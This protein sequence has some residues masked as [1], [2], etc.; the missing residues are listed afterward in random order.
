MIE[1]PNEPHCIECRLI[2]I[3]AYSMRTLTIPGAVGPSLPRVSIPINTRI[4][5]A[6][7]AAIKH[8]YGICTIQLAFLAGAQEASYYAVHEI[9]GPP[10][11]ALGVLSLT[12][13]N[14][15]AASELAGEQREIVL[16]IISGEANE[17]GRFA[18]VGWITELLA[19]TGSVLRPDSLPVIRQLNEGIDFCLLSLTDGDGRKLWFKAAGEPNSHEYALTQELAHRFPTYLPK[20]LAIVPEWNGWIME[21]ARGVPLSESERMDSCEQALTA[22]ATMQQEMARHA[23]SLSALGA[24]DWTCSRILSLSEPFFCEALCA[25]QRQTSTKSEPLSGNDLRQLKNEIESALAQFIDAGIP[26]TL[27]HGDIGHGNIIAT[28]RGPVFLDWAEA[29]LGHPFLSAEHLLADLSRSNPRFAKAQG[30]LRL[31]YAA[32]WTADV[33]PGV[34]EKIIALAS[35]MGAFAYAVAAWDVH[36]TRPDPSSAWPLM[37]SILRRTKKELG[38][39]RGGHCMNIP[40][41]SQSPEARTAR[42]LLHGTE[43]EDPFRWLEDQDAPA[44][45]SFIRTEQEN[46]RRYL[47]H[48]QE[49]RGR[50]ERRVRELLAVVSV[51]LPVSDHRGGVLYLKR[52]AEA[53]QKAIYCGDEVNAERLLISVAMLERDINTSLEIIQISP[54]GRHLVFGIRTGGEDVEEIGIYDLM[55]RHLLPDRLPR[56]FY[57]GLAFD[58]DQSGFYY[59]H[60]ETT[61]RYQHRRAVRKHEFGNDPLNDREVFHAGE[62]PSM[63]L[64]VR[65]AEDASAL[66]YHIVSLESASQ[67]R[68]LIHDFPLRTPPREIIHLSGSSFGPCFWANTIEASTTDGAPRGRIVR[69]SVDDP[70]PESWEDVIP[71]MPECF[72]SWERVGNLRI[73]HY[74]A[75]SRKLTRIFSE[76]GNL[77]RTI[78]YPM[79]GTST[80]GRVDG[81]AH[82]LFYSHSDVTKPATIYAVDLLNG[83]H[84]VWWHGPHSIQQEPIRIEHHTY[85]SKD[86]VDIPIT[87]TH[88][89]CAKGARPLLLSAYGGGGASTT[90]RFSALSTIL[91]ETGFICATAHVR[92]GGEGGLEWHLAALK[93]RK[94]TSVDDLLFAAHWLIA[95]GYTVRDRLGVAGQS[96]GALLTLCAMTQQPDL[97]RAVLA[98]GPIADLTRFHLFGV[99]RSAVAELGSPDDPDEFR[100]LYRLS[101]YHHVQRGTIYPA[102]LI[103]SGDLDK[104]CDAMHARKMI[105][106]LRDA[107]VQNMPILLDYTE[108]RGHKPSLP[109]SERIRSLADRLT[110]LVAELDVDSSEVQL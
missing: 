60:E 22:L 85:K 45:R 97:F 48:H 3:D 6:V 82:R 30:R 36:R 70:E 110:F 64:S 83:E 52:E 37:R 78:E 107:T 20:I 14:E 38:E 59:V 73:I 72:H 8:Q 71:E 77:V 74:T 94:Q 58:S 24:K 28:P 87:L 2:M 32:H 66:G 89:R 92:G 86:G 67:T 99:A 9:F 100:A 61:G 57:R 16:K 54:D 51:D 49:L 101:P 11:S 76:S 33:R 44:T 104:R 47:D 21:D 106:R 17:L 23:T 7:T 75:G 109:L 41:V 12:A 84:R 105:A 43:I 29:L 26:D 62:G 4:A 90:P 79:S 102:I 56:G 81:Y 35:A 19:K 91:S 98:L 95:N 18:R 46:Y 68:F 25:M 27:L 40:L 50:I 88:P 69:V 65:E 39:V 34:L 80:L 31:H 10:E 63:R 108:T 13:L 55:E 103:I 5:E 42:E 53:E 93:Q 1:I 15:I 96:N